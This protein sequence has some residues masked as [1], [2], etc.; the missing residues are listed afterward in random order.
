LPKTNTKEKKFNR[1][2]TRP[3]LERLEAPVAGEGV[4]EHIEAV[5]GNI[6]LINLKKIVKIRSFF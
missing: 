5:A 3:V 1:F 4:V 6:H 2:D